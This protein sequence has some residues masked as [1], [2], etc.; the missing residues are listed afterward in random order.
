MYILGEI[1][2][3]SFCS[4]RARLRPWPKDQ[5]LSWYLTW[6]R[7]PNSYH[8]SAQS[9]P[10]P[11]SPCR[12]KADDVK[13]KGVWLG[14]QGKHSTFNPQK[15]R[16]ANRATA[17]Q[18]SPIKMC[19]W[20]KSEEKVDIT[21][22]VFIS[23]TAEPHILEKMVPGVP[24]TWWGKAKKVEPDSVSLILLWAKLNQL[25]SR[26]ACSPQLYCDAKLDKIA[27]LWTTSPLA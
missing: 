23:L 19:C 13:G 11:F 8:P 18:N 2:F 4:S 7:P 15:R 22:R 25:I 21:I 6:G 9:H 5:L 10:S 16:M 3:I 17:D 20:G 12:R 14:I 27:S 26:G 1:K 24:Y